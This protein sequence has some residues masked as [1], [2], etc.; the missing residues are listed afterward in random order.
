MQLTCT[1]DLKSSVI[2]FKNL[3][4]QYTDRMRHINL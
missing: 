1:V 4:Y 3:G 2:S